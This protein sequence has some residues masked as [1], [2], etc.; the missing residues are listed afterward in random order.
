MRC[1]ST[2]LTLPAPRRAARP[3]GR[4]PV[5][6]GRVSR[7]ATSLP[8]LAL[9]AAIAAAILILRSGGAL[10]PQP[11]TAASVL[12]ASAAALDRIGGSRALGPGEYLYTRT[13]QWWRYARLQPPPVRRPEHP[14]SSGSRATGT[15]AAAMTSSA[16]AGRREPEPSAHALSGRPDACPRG[17][18]PFILSTSQPR[19]LF[20][21]A[22]LR[23]LPT[24]PTRLAAAPEPPRRAL[25]RQPAVP[26]TRHSARRSAGGC[27]AGLAETPTSAR[28]ARGAVPRARSDAGRSV[29]SAARATASAATAWRSRSMSRT[30]SSR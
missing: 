24:D 25:P 19:I 15:A 6:G 18:R 16:S 23:S 11:A 2:P 3:A 22:Q 9:A 13:A 14:G 12:S 10:A 28:A 4:Q 7:L 27:C 8:A 29:C 21:Y 26:A 17:S 1:S 20:S 30:P 5:G